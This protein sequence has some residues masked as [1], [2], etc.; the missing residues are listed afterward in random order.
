MTAVADAA[1]VIPH[2]HHMYHQHHQFQL[3]Y[4]V[5]LQFQFQFLPNQDVQLDNIELMEL[6]YGTLLLYQ[7]LFQIPAHQG[8]ILT[9]TEIVFHL[10]TQQPL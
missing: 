10:Q 6:V 7:N 3:S 2:H 5:H 1:V 4:Q 8:S 9:D